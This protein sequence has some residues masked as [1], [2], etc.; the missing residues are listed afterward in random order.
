MKSI[1]HL[2]GRTAAHSLFVLLVMLALP[3][4]ARSQ[5]SA[6]IVDTGAM[7]ATVVTAEEPA[8]TPLPTVTTT[9]VPPPAPSPTPFP[10][11]NEAEYNMLTCAA[12]EGVEGFVNF[13]AAEEGALEGLERIIE[14]AFYAAYG[15]SDDL[16]HHVWSH[17]YQQAGGAPADAAGDLLPYSAFSG[18]N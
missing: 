12:A 10:G 16:L 5:G 9:A 8:A 2:S 14:P 4:C 18:M 11:P 17:F 3:A 15:R 1:R 7:T 6:E 13:E